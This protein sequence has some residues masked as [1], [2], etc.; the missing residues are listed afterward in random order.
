MS[1]PSLEL[2]AA[3]VKRLKSVADVT[4]L[5]SSRVYDR[6]PTGP[7]FPYVSVGPKQILFDDIGCQTGFEI[8]IQLDAWSR[9]PGFQEAERIAETVRAALH[10]YDFSLTDNALVSFEHLQTR[11]LR[12]PDGLTSHAVIEFVALVEQP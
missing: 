2:Q 9:S 12:D 10:R 5:I 1:S 11:V 6:V 4:A 7:T 3:I 8:F